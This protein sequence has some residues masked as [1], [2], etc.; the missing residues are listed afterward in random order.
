MRHT[1]IMLIEH[2][3]AALGPDFKPYVP[4]LMPYMLKVFLYDNS[5]GKSVTVKCLEALK[6]CG[7]TVEE[8]LH[9]LVPPIVRLLDLR[10]TPPG[11]SK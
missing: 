5:E 9:L 10:D 3:A 6:V 4:G 11:V 7:P 2:I 1:I 8:H